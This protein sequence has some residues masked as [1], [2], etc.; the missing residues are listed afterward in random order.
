MDLL[1][2]RVN[3]DQISNLELNFIKNLYLKNP[4]YKFFSEPYGIYLTPAGIDYLK[5]FHPEIFELRKFNDVI[6]YIWNIQHVFIPIDQQGKYWFLEYHELID[7]I[8]GIML[9]YPI[10]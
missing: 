6:Y 2:Q 7:W 8:K 3:D 10:L 1:V 9:K 4:I 5:V